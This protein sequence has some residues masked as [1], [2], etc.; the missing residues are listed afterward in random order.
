MDVFV[1]VNDERLVVTSQQEPRV[2]PKVKPPTFAR[3]KVTAQ[4][5][6]STGNQ[7]FFHT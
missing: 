5:G 7:N 3:I 1:T 2:G 4:D 6:E